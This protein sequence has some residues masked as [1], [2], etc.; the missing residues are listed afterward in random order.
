MSNTES[1]E[2]LFIPFSDPA[3]QLIPR[4]TPQSLAGLQ[5]NLWRAATTVREN[6]FGRVE[7]EGRYV[8]SQNAQRYSVGY[9][10]ALEDPNGN[11]KSFQLTII[12]PPSVRTKLVSGRTYILTGIMDTIQEMGGKWKAVL[13]VDFIAGEVSSAIDPEQDALLKRRMELMT[14][15]TERPLRDIARVVT[16][17]VT[18]GRPLKIR[19]FY[20]KSAIVDADVRN[21]MGHASTLHPVEV[22]EDRIT[23][24]QSDVVVEALSKAPEADITAIVR[25]GGQGLD[26]FDNMDIAEAVVRY[27]GLIV[28]AVGHEQ[29]HPFVEKM[30]DR[31]FSTPTDFGN[32]ILQMVERAV[33]ARDGSRGKLI[34]QVK[35]PFEEEILSLRKSREELEKKLSETHTSLAEAGEKLRLELE[36]QFQ[37]R[38]E[39]NRKEFELR[40]REIELEAEKLKAERETLEKKI[41]EKEKEIIVAWQAKKRITL[42]AVFSAG[43]AVLFLL[44]RF[45]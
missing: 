24:S 34:E 1:A 31:A 16:D 20:G 26:L 23:M 3:K 14:S 41:S 5:L 27:P 6:N 28:T 8:E 10:D 43:V 32:C 38:N 36:K 35:K 39:N 12:V 17:A 15:K 11:G 7:V 37:T 42:T 4:F 45:I 2:T 19:I 29:N 13:K 44:L 18:E 25:G 33:E 30:A 40:T 22:V 21:G 9:Y